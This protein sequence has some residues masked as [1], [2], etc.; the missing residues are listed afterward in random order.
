MSTAYGNNIKLY[1]DGGSHDPYISMRLEGFPAGVKMDMDELQGFLARRAPGNGKYATARK[2]AD[3]PEFTSGIEEGISNGLPICAIIRN[4]NIRPGDYDYKN[5]PRP[6]HADYTAVIKYGENVNISGGGHF[7]GRLTAP[8]CIAGGLCMQYL[9]TLG[10]EIF[11]HIYSIA[12]V[13]DTPFDPVNVGKAEKDALSGMLFSVLNEDSGEKMQKAISDAK[14]NGDSVGGIIECAITGCPAGLGEHMFAG[15]EGRISSAVYSIPAIKGVEFG[16][17]FG[18]AKLNGS[19]NNDPFAVDGGKIVTETNNCGGILGGITNGM[20]IIFRAAVKPTPSIA[21]EQNTVSLSDKRPAKITVGGRHDPCIVPRAVPAV[22]AAAAVA[23]TDMLLDLNEDGELEDDLSVLRTKI[24]KYDRN[25]VNS[26]CKRMD[27]TAGVAAYKQKRGLPVLDAEREK[28]LLDKIE[29]LA[30]DD[31]AGYARVL[32]N[33]LLSVSRARQHRMLGGSGKEAEKLIA[34]RNEKHAL[35]PQ[36]ATVC[37]QGTKGAFSETAVKKI[38]KEPDIHFKP[39][40]LSVVEAVERGECQY[41][42]LPIENSTAGA[43][44]GIYNL[45]LSHPVY[46]VRSAVVE[47]EHNLLTNKGAKTEDIKEIFSHEQAINQCS[48]FLSS[49][50]DVKLTYCPNTAIAAELV[51]KSGRKDAAA[52]SSLSCAEI[53]GLDVL[54]KGAQNTHDNCTRFI[55]ISAKPEIYADSYTTDVIASTRNE[56]GALA[57]LLT[58]VYTFG[59]NIKKLES[60]PLGNGASGFYLSLDASADAADIAETLTSLEEYGTVFRWLGTYGVTQ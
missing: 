27:V 42:I 13:Y 52:L 33:T 50:G 2:E 48:V 8:Y 23:I 30:G 40:F 60:M 4:T 44:T 54:R 58:R 18:V 43:V 49:L 29:A 36:K 10:I 46:I 19:Q 47:V 37:A 1:I 22:E 39:S 3:I 45:L 16:A 56:P 12:N 11:A 59:I 53:Y 51:A 5:T 25:I 38:F 7:S 35:F 15:T 26:F 32:Y 34:A 41:G 9:K 17:G 20:P 24:D 14:A 31:L 21:K 55:C 28:K 57:S 6:G